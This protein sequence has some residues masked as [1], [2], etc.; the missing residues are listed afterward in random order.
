MYKFY[1]SKNIIDWGFSSI[2][3][4]GT[5]PFSVTGVTLDYSQSR[6]L[7]SLFSFCTFIQSFLQD[8]PNDLVKRNSKKGRSTSHYTNLG[9]PK[10]K[11]THCILCSQV[12]SIYSWVPG[13]SLRSVLDSSQRL[14]HR[15]KSRNR[16]I[17]VVIGPCR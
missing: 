11:P 12:R 15:V 10:S 2:L 4:S 14:Y 16:S 1:S 9:L 17:G 5:S 6:G 13:L 7:R 8:Y 3:I